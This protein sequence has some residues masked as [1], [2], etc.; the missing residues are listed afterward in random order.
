[1]ANTADDISKQE[2]ERAYDPANFFIDPNG[3]MDL[4]ATRPLITPQGVTYIPYVPDPSNL[5]MDSRDHGNCISPVTTGIITGVAKKSR[6]VPIK[7]KN[8]RGSATAV[9]VQRGDM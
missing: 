5:M 7:Y 1:M 8:S 2:H 3:M 4:A 6:L 9:A